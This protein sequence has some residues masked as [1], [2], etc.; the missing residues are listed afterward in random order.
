M[1]PKQPLREQLRKIVLERVMKGV[2]P[3]G[4]RIVESALSAELGVSRTP[5]REALLDLTKEGLL[6][7]DLAR[8]FTV[9]P[10]TAREVQEMYPILWTLECLALRMAQDTPDFSELDDLNDQLLQA[11]GEPVSALEIDFHWHDLLIAGCLNQ[12]LHE[13]IADL[14]KTIRRYEYSFM[15]D[16]ELIHRSHVQHQE[17]IAALKQKDIELASQLLETHWRTGMSSLMEQITI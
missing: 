5:L 13:M 17:I 10:L 7:S 16:A 15:W 8:G 14:K 3:A 9:R 2:F 4:S 11:K 6:R 12:R 1:S